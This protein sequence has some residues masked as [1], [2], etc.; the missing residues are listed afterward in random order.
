MYLELIT[1][2]LK[3]MERV[4][5][6]LEKMGVHKNDISRYKEM[7]KDLFVD[8]KILNQYEIKGIFDTLSMTIETD[9]PDLF[10]EVEDDIK[11]LMIDYE[12]DSL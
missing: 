1:K 11:D 3:K 5:I 4:F 8:F 9:Y 10:I 2:T 12:V 7:V 6:K